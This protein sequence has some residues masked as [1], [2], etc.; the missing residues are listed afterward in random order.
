MVTAMPRNEYREQVEKELRWQ[1]WIDALSPES[2]AAELRE[3]RDE[4][5]SVS[6]ILVAALF[7]TAITVPVAIY[8][9]L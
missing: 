6:I 3:K 7:A 5:S 8:C 9:S 1:R 4:E 2:R